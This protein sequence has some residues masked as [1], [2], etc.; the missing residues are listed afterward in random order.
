LQEIQSISVSVHTDCF[1]VIH[2]CPPERDIL[3]SVGYPWAEKV[4]ELATV[5]SFLSYLFVLLGVLEEYLISFQLY[6]QIQKLCKRTTPIHF[7]GHI[8]YNNS[9]DT[10][11][12]GADCV[13]SFTLNPKLKGSDAVFQK[14]KGNTAVVQYPPHW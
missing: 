13:L 14:G 11:S 12:K 5:V 1:M 6:Q 3:L 8:T 4:S 7:G 9:R 10:K 2:M